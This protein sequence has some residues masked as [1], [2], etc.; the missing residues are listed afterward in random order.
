MVLPQHLGLG[1]FGH[2]GAAD[3]DL[4]V[5]DGLDLKLLLPAH[6]KAF[7]LPVFKHRIAV[8]DVFPMVVAGGHIAVALQH[9]KGHLPILGVEGQ[10]VAGVQLNDAKLQLFQAALADLAK[11]GVANGGRIRFFVIHTSSSNI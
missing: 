8:A 7:G 9:N 11:L 2:G 10:T 3:G 6:V 1:F 4:D 5:V